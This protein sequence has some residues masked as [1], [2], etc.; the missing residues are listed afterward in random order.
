MKPDPA[1]LAWEKCGQ[2]SCI[3][4][5]FRDNPYCLVHQGGATKTALALLASEPDFGW[6]R[7]IEIDE[8]LMVQI[9]TAA[10]RGPADEPVFQN[11]DFTA[12]HF[13]GAAAFGRADFQG[14]AI[15]NSCQFDK[16]ADFG[17]ARFEGN[18]HFANATF[19]GRA[20]FK[21]VSIARSGYFG[22]L[23]CV[24]DATFS[25]ASSAGCDFSG[26]SFHQ[27]AQFQGK[28]VTC[29]FEAAVF[30]REVQFTAFHVEQECCLKKVEF[31]SHHD[32]GEI[33]SGRAID[34]REAKFS[35]GSIVGLAAPA[36]RAGRLRASVG[37]RIEFRGDLDLEG[38]EFGGPT[39][40]TSIPG[41][42]LATR[43]RTGSPDC[44]RITNLTR[45]DVSNLTIGDVD[46]SICRLYGSHGL[47]SMKT[48]ASA[49]WEV[50][51]PSR[52]RAHRQ[53]II[54]EAMWRGRRVLALRNQEIGQ[55]EFRDLSPWEKL[56]QS[57]INKYEAA[58]SNHAR[59]LP[60]DYSALEPSGVARIYRALRKGREDEKDA[61]GAD[62]F[63]YGEMEMRR[64]SERQ[65]PRH[66]LL[67]FYW[68]VSGYGLR[69]WRAL[70]SLILLVS[71]GGIILTM[72]GFDKIGASTLESVDL[73][74]GRF[75]YTAN[76]D[77]RD[78]WDGYAYAIQA[79]TSLV[80]AP[81]QTPLT[82]PGLVVEIVLRFAG[83]LL[84]GLAI[85]ALRGRLKR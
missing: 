45:A 63:Y 17:A 51:P 36:I 56:A 18:C 57:A 50:S 55:L 24:E 22:K 65:I 42:R 19:G 31:K 49:R 28:H 20:F 16:N 69:A 15:F 29:T 67:T 44:A 21:A 80:R 70:V 59:N 58:A 27:L 48:D 30:E 71:A 5:R 3:G 43:S 6:F 1:E 75:A 13:I 72:W 33:F 52:L 34:L 73:R 11:V 46:L 77:A 82:S 81:D 47:D 41:E 85:L 68:L 61:P 23:T 12:A 9:R 54:E 32:I 37:M 79:A 8:R 2:S 4:V 78:L 84:L 10:A 62:D 35:N 39:I 64:R 74:T 38:A 76:T 40:I 66:F 60:F 83:P 25:F 53:I 26:S 14:N 7:G